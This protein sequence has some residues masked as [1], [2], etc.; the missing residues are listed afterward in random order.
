M[1]GGDRVV[2]LG[3]LEVEDE[4]EHQR[5]AREAVDEG[6]AAWPRRRAGSGR[7]SG[8][9]SARGRG[10]RSARTAA[11]ARRP[12][13]ARR[14][15]PGRS[16]RESPPREI[17]STRPVSPTTKVDRARAGRSRARVSGLASSRRISPPQSA[18]SERERDVEP[19]DPV[20]GDR[21][22]RAAE[23]RADHEADGGDHRVRPHR[24]AELLARE[25]VGDQRGGV[26]E[27]ERA[28]DALQ[29][30]ARGSARCRSAAKPAPERGE[31]RRRRSRRRR[32]VLRPNRSD[33]RPAVSTSTV[34]AI[35]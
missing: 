33:S 35:M 6:G 18:P 29:R 32:R 8:R 30:S 27:Q 2:A 11:A 10:A 34:E 25:R 24:Q 23:H 12:R 21:D 16:S 19:E 9:A 22:E 17:P 26:G 5:E 13:R 28:A 1:P 3:A 31:R 4:H 14:R 20:P 15:R 7:S